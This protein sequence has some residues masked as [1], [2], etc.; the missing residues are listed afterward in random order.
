MFASV[1]SYRIWFVAP[2]HLADGSEIEV[3]RRAP[4]DWSSPVDPQTAQRGFRWSLYLLAVVPKGL[5]EPSFQKLYPPLLEY[6]C[7][8]WNAHNSREHRLVH[9]GLVGMVEKIP[10]VGS[11]ANGRIERVTIA[12]RDCPMTPDI[13]RTP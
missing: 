10:E 3:L 9:I 2:G 12:T 13:L 7:R 8:E 6:L 11:V 4:M 1:G 5:T